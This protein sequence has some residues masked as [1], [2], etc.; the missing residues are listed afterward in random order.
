MNLVDAAGTQLG[1]AIPQF[2]LKNDPAKV[3]RAYR[4]K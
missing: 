3:R 4:R 2:P 1:T